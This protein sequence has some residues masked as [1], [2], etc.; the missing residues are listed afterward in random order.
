MCM[1]QHSHFLLVDSGKHGGKAWGTETE[2]RAALEDYLSD[3]KGVPLVQLVS[4]ARRA[5]PLA[6][7]RAKPMRPMSVS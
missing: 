4:L 7:Q 1:S 3:S 2:M 5:E 6:V